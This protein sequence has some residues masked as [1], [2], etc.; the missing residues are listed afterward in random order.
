MNFGIWRMTTRF[1]ISDQLVHNPFSL[2][3]KHHPNETLVKCLH[4]G[5]TW[6]FFEMNSVMGLKD[7][8]CFYSFQ[9]MRFDG[10]YKQNPLGDLSIHWVILTSPDYSGGVSKR[11]LDLVPGDP[12]AVGRGR[13]E[14]PLP[15]MPVTSPPY[16]SCRVQRASRRRS[17]WEALEPWA[18]LSRPGRWDQ[19]R[20]NKWTLSREEAIFLYNFPDFGWFWMINW[21]LLGTET[22]HG[23]SSPAKDRLRGL[24]S[25]VLGPPE[26]AAALTSHG[27]GLDKSR[28]TNHRRR[29]RSSSKRI[30]PDA[31]WAQGSWGY[32]N[33]RNFV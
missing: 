15:L 9:L 11:S 5:Q 23:S 13:G 8:W 30:R 32:L 12:S 17:P 6:W 26:L 33:R 19:N 27:H 1:D 14:G 2:S 3:K 25:C 20:G 28:R 22:S 18:D 31:A 10:W 4:F 29:S 16:S 7:I 21:V 24:G